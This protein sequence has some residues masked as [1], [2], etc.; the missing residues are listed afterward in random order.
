MKN[1]SV[2]KLLEKKQNVLEEKRKMVKKK[3]TNTFTIIADLRSRAI[4]QSK[5]YKNQLRDSMKL[6]THWAL[7]GYFPLEQK[8]CNTKTGIEK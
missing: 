6:N 2:K 4:K 7:P 5:D 1:N 3:K 8:Q